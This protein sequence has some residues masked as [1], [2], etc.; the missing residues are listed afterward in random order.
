MIS[1]LRLSF[2]ETEEKRI[3]RSRPLSRRTVSTTKT[4]TNV[5]N[6][7]FSVLPSEPYRYMHYAGKRHR[8]QQREKRTYVQR[9][10]SVNAC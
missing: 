7:Y 9:Y 6:K 1:N 8:Q 5:G 10:Q 2:L 4:P 3:S